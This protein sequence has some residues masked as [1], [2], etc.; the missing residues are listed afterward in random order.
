M[1]I[2]SNGTPVY[3]YNIGRGYY[4]TPSG[5]TVTSITDTVATNFLGYTNLV[6]KLNSPVVAKGAVTLTWSAVEGGSYEVEASTNLTSWTVLASNLSPN[7]ITGS[8]TNNTTLARNNYRV[9]RTAVAAYDS[10]GATSINGSGGTGGGAT[11]DAP[12]GTVSPGTTV[13]VSITLP[14]NPPAP[15][16][17]APITTVKLGG[18]S[19]TA[20]SDATSGTVI[21][22]FVIPANATAGTE[23]I[24]V[25]FASP[26]PTITVANALT[27]E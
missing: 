19:G 7:Q 17:N 14:A 22:T 16:A 24:V 2:A 18:I 25:T 10:A 9:L 27:I 15:P 13:T 12:G 26:G 5:G 20:I 8:Y 4:G 1:A 23:N 6:Q 3:P 21:A 11:V